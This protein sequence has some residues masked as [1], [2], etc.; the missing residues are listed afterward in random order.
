M[1]EET[2]LAAIDIGSNSFRLEIG[3][4]VNGHIEPVEC[5]K[6][7][8]RLGGG[9]TPS[10]G[11]TAAAMDRG[12]ACL[13][14]FAERIRD[15][16]PGFVRA[17]ATQTLREACN[18][19]EFVATA[20][21]I[22]GV[23]VEVIAGQEEARLIYHGVHQAL[24]DSNERRLVIDI[25]GRST[26]VICGV[27][28]KV[29][30]LD[31]FPVGSVSWSER[32][33]PKGVL[34]R[35]RFNEAITAA[36]AVFEEAQ[37]RFNATQ[38]EMAYGAS[39]TANATANVLRAVGLA[40]DGITLSDLNWLVDRLCKARHCEDIDLAG[41]KE[42]RKPV[43]GGGIS[44]LYALMQMFEI[45][46]LRPTKGA[47]R[48]GALADMVSRDSPS[49]DVRQR[50]VHHLM[51]RF[52]VDEQH[53]QRVERV[54]L[55]LLDQMDPK[56]A[57]PATKRQ[58]LKWAALLHEIGC[59]ISHGDSPTHGAYLLDHVEAPGFSIDEL[60]RLALLVQG[61]RGKLRRVSDALEDPHFRTTLLS[62]RLA[63]IFCHARRA[64]ELTG[65]HLKA[66]KLGV[67]VSLP[68][69][70]RDGFPQSFWNLEQEVYSWRRY[71]NYL[72][73]TD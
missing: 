5:L 67:Q 71:E 49:G 16:K 8:V 22:L 31:S 66:A 44:V 60:H 41:L 54:A 56:R 3:K 43:I 45:P 59:V 48:Q 64:P 33:F 24:P 50:T 55:E 35:S 19:A 34:T 70:W 27:G 23:E 20:R 14:R 17:V 69:A 18:R 21:K 46:V 62:L 32:Y 72:S 63:C 11:L 9:L 39:G 29:V 10:E 38:W 1:Q 25:G 12:W 37:A 4:Y 58:D 7:T 61:Q 15:F 65:V 42:E 13:E 57:M 2:L 30:D 28:S 26:E 53:A 52:R 47:L 51:K 6:E 73:I 68:H 40:Q 36:K